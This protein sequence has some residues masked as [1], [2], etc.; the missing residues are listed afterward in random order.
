MWNIRRS[1]P[2]Y[3]VHRP[4]ARIRTVKAPQNP[5]STPL[6][7]GPV[8]LCSPSHSFI[9]ATEE[10][11]GCPAGAGVVPQ[12]RANTAGEAF[13]RSCFSIGGVVIRATYEMEPPGSAETFALRESIG[14]EGG[15]D[16]ARGRVVG[17]DSGRAVLEFPEANWGTNVSL[18]MSTLVAG[19]GGEIGAI[20]RCRL[21]ELE[22]P[23]G[24]WPG[25]AFGPAA[26]ARPVEVGVI[27]KPSLGLSPAEVGEVARAAVAGGAGFIKDDEILGDPE[28][29]PLDA[30][31][32]AVAKALEPGVVYCANI[33][34]ASVTLVDRARRVVELGA[35]GV[36][37]NAF[38][39]GLDGVLALRQ[40]D[41]GVPILAH[42]AGS[43]ALTRNE[44][45]GARG[46]V[47][48]RL[49][50][51]CGA[52]YVIVGAFGGSLFDNDAEVRASLDAARGGCGA[53]AAAIAMFGGGLGPDDIVAQAARAGGSGLVMVLGSRAYGHRGGIE[54]GVRAA[55]SAVGPA[56]AS[57]GR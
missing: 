27:V 15:P 24:F 47:L 1:V 43:G 32:R 14:M 35:T 56:A 50:R 36:M 37:V 20:T 57:A 40:A 31:V 9:G 33:T 29:C 46:S 13:P 51:L 4:T 26:Q 2:I 54:G 21:V 8:Y 55:V 22:F 49:C 53:A 41:L 23:D 12:R 19:E 7:R 45:F 11:S 38:A 52:D 44:R 10:R 3:G 42:R 18:L 28:W 17:E 39:Q 48:A 25:P 34:G 6:T 16:S 5:P 30:R